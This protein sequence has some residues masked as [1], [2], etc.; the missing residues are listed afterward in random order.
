M[1]ISA[2]TIA[3][4]KAKAARGSG[5]ITLS[6]VLIKSRNS[7]L[8]TYLLKH[9]QKE[10]VATNT[11]AS[12]LAA[13]I[14][15]LARSGH[16][17]KA[18]A[19]LHSI[20]DHAPGA[21]LD[22]RLICGLVAVCA[23]EKN[24]EFGDELRLKAELMGELQNAHVAT[25]LISL[26]GRCGKFGEA[27]AVHDA[28][29]APG[30]AEISAAMVAV[31]KRNGMAKEAAKFAKDLKKQKLGDSER[32]L[33]SRTV[34][35]R[36]TIE[37]TTEPMLTTSAAPED[38]T[39]PSETTDSLPSKIVNGNEERTA[40]ATAGSE[41]STAILSELVDK[42]LSHPGARKDL[43]KEPVSKWPSVTGLEAIISYEGYRIVNRYAEKATNEISAQ[44]LL[45]TC[46]LPRAIDLFGSLISLGLAL[47]ESH[48]RF[49]IT[50]S[51]RHTKEAEAGV[52]FWRYMVQ[53]GL[54]ASYST[55]GALSHT[56]IKSA[57][58]ELANY[59]LEAMLRGDVPANTDASV[60]AGIIL[61]LART[62]NFCKA[63]EGLKWVSENAPAA[64]HHRLIAGLLPVCASERD[65]EFG[66]ELRRKAE[67]IGALEEAYVVCGFIRLYG[68]CGRPIE[69]RAV[70]DACPAAR[71]NSKIMT[72]M[73]ATY[74]EN[75]MTDDAAEIVKAMPAFG[76]KSTVSLILALLNGFDNEENVASARQLIA[77]MKP[78][79]NIEQNDT[80]MDRFA[81]MLIRL[82][83][84]KEATS[85]LR[86]ISF[87]SNAAVE[88]LKA[89]CELVDDRGA[90]N[91][92]RE[93]LRELNRRRNITGPQLADVASAML[94]ELE[95]GNRDGSGEAEKTLEGSDLK[96]QMASSVVG[97]VE[98]ML[99]DV[100]VKASS[101]PNRNAPVSS[102]KAGAAYMRRTY[103]A[104]GAPPFAAEDVKSAIET[105]ATEDV[106]VSNVV[107]RAQETEA[108]A[109]DIVTRDVTTLF[110]GGSSF[111]FTDRDPGQM[112]CRASAARL[113]MDM[114]EAEVIDD[115]D[116]VGNG[117]DLTVFER[118]EILAIVYAL[119]NSD[120]IA[121][122]LTKSGALDAGSHHVIAA[123]AR[124]FERR[125]IVVDSVKTYQF[126]AGR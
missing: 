98:V 103:R 49:M 14:L 95:A 7:E 56:A 86:R 23:A 16:L 81:R 3:R 54:K 87:V 91:I 82:G 45:G 79:Y 120:G 58:P 84:V 62:D 106:R 6:R 109:N 77:R 53:E 28:L 121:V 115:R 68:R 118:S 35:A 47:N 33:V 4:L 75:G 38:V 74:I 73:M 111:S 66:E 61:T 42:V 30:R 5:I 100:A 57:N 48:I 72:A 117:S 113:E 65:R 1:A 89:Q 105:V 19:A 102:S 123:I 99:R 15:A 17:S 10:K 51:N 13:L 39:P 40:E 59:L 78:D 55:L 119:E 52:V 21:A 76:V 29:P 101:K 50:M 80:L 22:A 18:R 96:S 11:R 88:A 116:T 2:E 97:A 110:I 124:L 112:A 125:I 104:D 107:N 92:A 20:N 93:R 63:K 67:S 36:T 25:A 126:E 83:H 8:A 34:M 64:I 70:Y 24:L 46:E 9:L 44:G 60:F 85:Y 94:G 108:E 27:R 90:A 32:T 43:I 12:I 26:Y 71:G 37:A 41:V 31:Y 114:R 69:A 122:T